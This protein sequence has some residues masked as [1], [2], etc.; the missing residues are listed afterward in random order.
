MGKL[1]LPDDIKKMDIPELTELAKEIRELLVDTVSRTGGHLASNLGVVD[2][3]LALYKVFDFPTDKVVW[4]VG[5]QSYVHKILSGRLAEFDTLRQKGGLSG[6]PKRSESDFDSFNTGHSSTAISAALGLAR[7]RDLNY[8]DYHVMAVVGDGAL[9]GGM[10]YEAMND[11]GRSPN[12]LIVILN[13]NEMS[14]AGNVGGISRHLSKIR[15]TPRYFGLRDE[16][17]DSV[18]KVPLVGSALALFISKIKNLIKYALIPGIIF[19]ELGFK[20]I[21]PVDGHNIGD[22]VPLL[23]GV[24]KMRGPILIHAL[25]R[26]G[27]GYPFAELNPQKFHGVSP[28]RPDSGD[29]LSA[30]KQSFSSVF[31]RRLVELA[32]KD[33]KIVAV[34]AAMI[35]GT[36]LDGFHKAF[37]KRFFDVGIAEQHAV[38]MAAGLSLQGI[39][40]VVALYS[41]FL[42]RAYDQLL[43]DVCFQNA[44]VVFAVD[45]AGIVGEDGETHQGL[46]D[47]GFLR[48]M[49][50]MTV[51]APG[52]FHELEKMLDFALLSSNGPIA[53]R[54][55]RGGIDQ[56][57]YSRSE[58]LKAS[59]GISLAAMTTPIQMGKAVTLRYGEDITVLALGIMVEVAVKAAEIANRGKSKSAAASR[60]AGR[61]VADQR[62]DSRVD[63]R[64][65]SRVDRISVE[66][67]DA[68]FVKP[69]DRETILQSVTKTGRLLVVEDGC[70][71]G[72]FGSAVLELLQMENLRCAVRICAFPDKPIDHASRAELLDQYGLSAE[73]IAA[74]IESLIVQR[75]C[76]FDDHE[77]HFDNNLVRF[78]TVD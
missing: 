51:M 65:E 20:Y 76:V 49:P 62:T 47:I 56:A 21:G 43:H 36:G 71:T 7:A 5:H 39:K 41:T 34:S 26:K 37:P 29:F 16:I 13:D 42:Q 44:P 48:Q 60:S 50:G 27:S 23:Q 58:K 77:K 2:L 9:T 11:A 55:P 31:G 12:N 78:G 19:E 63:S 18:E 24:S 70:V 3:T 10:C 4:D 46:Y 40:P 68:R 69:L 67:I 73:R 61:T 59:D 15:S 57:M 45:R 52:N 1:S 72:G 14:I 64:T 75:D 74:E 38:T 25:T 32:R 35:S 30:G 6:F 17:H 33:D 22:L 8:D 28:F 54:Y 53:I 66:L